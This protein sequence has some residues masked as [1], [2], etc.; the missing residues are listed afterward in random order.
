MSTLTE[1]RIG[2]GDISVEDQAGFDRVL[3]GESRPVLVS[4]SGDIIELPKALSDLLVSVFEAMKQRQAVFLVHE[5]EAYTTQAAADFLGMSRQFFVRILD[6]GELPFHHV[7][8][9][10]RVLFKD[11]VAYRHKRNAKRRALLDRMTD[12]AVGSSLDERYVDLTR[13]DGE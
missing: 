5:D 1:N 12:E 2:P 7:G 11:L 3:K 9:H 4:G 6:A 13:P 10:R 8:T